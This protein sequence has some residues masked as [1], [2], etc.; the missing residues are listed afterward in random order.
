MDPHQHLS[1]NVGSSR[2]RLTEGSCV[3]GLQNNAPDEVVWAGFGKNLVACCCQRVG[4]PDV[5]V[6]YVA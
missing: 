3:I 1:Q 2:K 4:Y 5:G 6:T